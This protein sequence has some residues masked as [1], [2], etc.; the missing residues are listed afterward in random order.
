MRIIGLDICKSSVAACLLTERP[1]EPR[2]FYYDCKF[3]RFKADAT[4]IKAML[5]QKADIAGKRTDRRQLYA[6]MGYALS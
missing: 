4:G 3:Y 1:T 2:Q 5:E 6:L